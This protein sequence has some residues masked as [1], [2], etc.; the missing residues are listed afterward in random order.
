VAACIIS[1]TAAI[2]TADARERPQHFAAS[3]TTAGLSKPP[4]ERQMC[5]KTGEI[6]RLWDFIRLAII[7]TVRRI[8]S[9]TI[10]YSDGDFTEWRPAETELLRAVKLPPVQSGCLLSDINGFWHI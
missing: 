10:P 5:C 6:N 7:E 2:F 3:S 8:S 4:E 1:T 9:C